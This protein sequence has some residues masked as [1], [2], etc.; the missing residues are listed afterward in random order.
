MYFKNGDLQEYIKIEAES[1]RR[2]IP[3]GEVI[4]MSKQMLRGL[5]D[6]HSINVLHR[7]LKP[8]YIVN[9]CFR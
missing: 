6:L 4:R 8:R 7:N 3:L 1:E 5:H 2:C 9:I